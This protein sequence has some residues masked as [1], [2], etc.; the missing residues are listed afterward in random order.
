MPLYDDG[1]RLIL[2]GNP[3][4]TTATAEPRARRRVR[5]KRP[6]AD[7]AEEREQSLDTWN[8]AGSS[9]DPLPR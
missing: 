1:N 5:D 4:T 8:G 2:E 6:P 3:A 9:T 7:A